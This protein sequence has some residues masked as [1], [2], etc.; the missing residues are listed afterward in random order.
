MLSQLLK[1]FNDK[2]DAHNQIIQFLVSQKQSLVQNST[3]S[4]NEEQKQQ[5]TN[6]ANIY[7]YSNEKIIDYFLRSKQN[8]L[9]QLDIANWWKIDREK[10]LSLSYNDIQNSF[11]SMQLQL[12]NRSQNPLLDL[13]F[14]EYKFVIHWDDFKQHL[15][16][17]DAKN[18]QWF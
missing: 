15:T 7:N 2:D 16:Q 5:I 10:G 4:L 12:L 3:T 8:W 11:K 14:K 17:I 1:L 13:F 6:L 18:C 9:N